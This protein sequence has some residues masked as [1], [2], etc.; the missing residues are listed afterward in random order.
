[1][2]PLQQHL[3][4]DPTVNSTPLLQAAAW[5]RT[6]KRMHYLIVR[7]LPSNG[8]K[9]TDP[10]E[11][12]AAKQQT[13]RQTDMRKSFD[14]IYIDRLILIPFSPF[15]CFPLQS[16]LIVHQ[17]SQPPHTR[18]NTSPKYKEHKEGE[19]AIIYLQADKTHTASIQDQEE[20][21]RNT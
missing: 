2:F 18:H 12:T 3:R 20:P 17:V 4:T 10:K 21:Q 8:P 16:L 1:M 9:R 5:E 11:N 7:P 6:Q 13:D 19:N 15:S 14:F